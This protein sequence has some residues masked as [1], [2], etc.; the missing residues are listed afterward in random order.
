LQ[1][2]PQRTAGSGNKITTIYL[3]SNPLCLSEAFLGDISYDWHSFFPLLGTKD[4]HMNNRRNNEERKPR[5]RF[6]VRKAAELVRSVK[7]SGERAQEAGNEMISSA[8]EKFNNLF[9]SP[10]SQI[11]MR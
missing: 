4:D 9:S 8:A 7:L 3:S 2:L 10:N 6:L 5:K 11:Q 1:H